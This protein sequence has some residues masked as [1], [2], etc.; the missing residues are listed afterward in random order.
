VD[1]TFGGGKGKMKSGAKREVKFG[2]TAFVLNSES[3]Y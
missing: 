1:K 2:L 3:S